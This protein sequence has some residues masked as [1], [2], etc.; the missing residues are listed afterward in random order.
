MYVLYSRINRNQVI[1]NIFI[2]FS[3]NSVSSVMADAISPFALYTA[4]FLLAIKIFVG[5]SFNISS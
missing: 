2:Y 5:S 4:T 1:T 3:S